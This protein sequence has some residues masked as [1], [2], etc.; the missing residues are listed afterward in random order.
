MEL[1]RFDMG[2]MGDFTKGFV[3]FTGLLWVLAILGSFSTGQ[4]AIAILLLI[5]LIIPVSL[6]FAEHLKN[7]KKPI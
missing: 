1:M 5:V 7:R 2:L 6:I 4:T 3:I